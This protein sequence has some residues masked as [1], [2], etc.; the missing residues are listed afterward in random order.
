ME[1]NGEVTK[2]G[3]LPSREELTRK[4]VTDLYI[5]HAHDAAYDA[6]RD[7]LSI[8]DRAVL[9]ENCNYAESKEE[10][11]DKLKA[12][13]KK[14]DPRNDFVANVDGAEIPSVAYKI[15]RKDDLSLKSADKI[16]SY[17]EKVASK[18]AQDFVESAN[19]QN[20]SVER[21]EPEI[22]SSLSRN[23]SQTDISDNE[24][25][26]NSDSDKGA[27]KRR[28]SFRQEEKERR[29]DINNSATCCIIM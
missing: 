5:E 13:M 15:L 12:T 20:K 27:I 9:D 4:G 24:Q 8:K 25:E 17:V 26:K 21:V 23:N 18:N 3:I 14:Q 7:E 28:A 2:K 6:Y 29:A 1:E 22:V 16:A 10:Y 19:V 11:I